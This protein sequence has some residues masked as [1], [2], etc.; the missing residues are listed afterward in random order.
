MAA[1]SSAWD[2]AA[3]AVKGLGLFVLG[4]VDVV[5][6]V[7]AAEVVVDVSVYEGIGFKVTVGIRIKLLPCRK[8]EV[9]LACRQEG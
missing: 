9:V 7:D 1:L 2:F 8:N 6:K 4:V 5:G 3:H